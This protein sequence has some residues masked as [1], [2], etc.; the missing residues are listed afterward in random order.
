MDP[1]DLGEGHSWPHYPPPTAHTSQIWKYGSE[2][3]LQVPTTTAEILVFSFLHSSHS[4]NPWSGFP[5]IFLGLAFASGKGEAGHVWQQPSPGP[6]GTGCSQVLGV[7]SLQAGNI[8]RNVKCFQKWRCMKKFLPWKKICMFDF[9]LQF[10]TNPFALKSRFDCYTPIFC[11]AK[12][13]PFLLENSL[14]CQSCLP[15]IKN[16]I[17][18]LQYWTFSG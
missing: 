14:H 18:K 13:L 16:I 4:G 3:A 6:L 9:L 2:A 1:D 15:F 5:A 11:T 17:T 7:C 10:G 12:I 8:G